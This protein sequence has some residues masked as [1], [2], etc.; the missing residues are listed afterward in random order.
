MTSDDVSKIRVCVMRFLQRVVTVI[1]RPYIVREL[2]GWGRV[3]QL[4]IGDYRRNWFWRNALP[5]DVR[6]KRHGY[7]MRLDLSRWSDRA[8]YFL[9]RWYA[10]DIQLFIADVLKEGNVVVDIGSNRGMFALAASRIVGP[11]G[12]V[13]CFEPNPSCRKILENEIAANSIGNIQ[14]NPCALGDRTSEMTL[15][16]PNINSGE[17][18]FGYSRYSPENTKAIV[19]GV[20]RGDDLLRGTSPN[21]IKIDVEGFERHVI[22][23]LCQTIKSY[24]PLIIMEV[25]PGHLV[26]CGSTVDELKAEMRRLGY[27][28]YKLGLV[29]KNW[30]YD[31][32]LSNTDFDD[33]GTDWIWA[34]RDIWTEQNPELDAHLV[35]ETAVSV[36]RLSG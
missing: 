35:S 4:F 1:A 16:V 20:R 18:T 22:S 9:G 13:I 19:A 5:V 3:F 32:C 14:I 6:G 17:G 24:N 36:S 8:T 10:L 28:P 11:D 15:T 2:P 31:W 12:S 34:P 29:R 27:V 30:N 26:A 33:I 23:G 21:L 25:I 7:S